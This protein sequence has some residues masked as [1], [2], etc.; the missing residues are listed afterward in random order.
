MASL[1]PRTTKGHK[2]WS[3]V[4]SRRVNGK[5]TP[6]IVQYLG[7]ADALLKRLNSTVDDFT[8]KSY[9]HGSVVA[10]LDIAAKIGVPDIINQHIDSQ[11]SYFAEK[12]LRNDLTAGMTLLLAAIGRVCKPTSK[13]GWW[14]WAQTTSLEYLLKVSLSKL[15]SSHYWDMMDSLPVDNIEK[16][17]VELLQRIKQVYNLESDTLLFDTTNFYTYI[18]STNS[19]CEIAKRGKNKQRRYDLRQFGLALVVTKK[20]NIPIF[21]HTYEGNMN[22][23][24]VFDQVIGKIKKR[25][26]DLDFD[27][28][29]HTIVFDRGNNSKKN[30]TFLKELELFYVGA[31]TPYHHKELLE[32]AND[33]FETVTVKNNK[34]QVYREK[35]V[36]W[37]GERTIL[38]II[39][40]K[41]RAGQLRGIYQALSKKEKQ[42]EKLAG[43]LD[44]PKA[45]KRDRE[46]L[47]EKLKKIGTISCRY[48]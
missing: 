44:S 8:Y 17:E 27:L 41:L 12:P 7:T 42:L 16:I 10:L 28:N 1:Q 19:H 23:T 2:Y 31:L 24:K 22:D 25:L 14:N 9:S 29:K 26:V 33:N 36:I 21:H 15:D 39:S 11:R 20:D 5:P 37:D 3:I 40:E 6:F 47:E 13:D 32:R 46:K 4:E 34:I 48:N 18:S 38:V 30:L 43:A 45:K 35:S